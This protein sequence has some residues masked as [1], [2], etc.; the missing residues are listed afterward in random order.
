MPA[1]SEKRK[2]KIRGRAKSVPN[3]IENEPTAKTTFP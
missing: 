3:S 2:S 1:P